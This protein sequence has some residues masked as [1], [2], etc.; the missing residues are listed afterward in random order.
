MTERPK[1]LV[2]LSRIF[3]TAALA[4]LFSLPRLTRHPWMRNLIAV[5]FGSMLSSRYHQVISFYGD[6]YGEALRIAL[7]RAAAELDP[8]PRRILDCGTGTG[9][10]AREARR[11]FPT[12]KV[13]G[14][15]VVPGMLIRARDGLSA[16]GPTLPAV[17]A[18]SLFIPFGDQSVDLVLSQNSVP[19]LDEFARVCR[20]GGLVIFVD[21][22]ATWMPP[23]ARRAAKRTGRFGH[24]VSESAGLGFYLLARR[25]ESTD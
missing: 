13:M 10:A 4:P 9:F 23:I 12:A 25:A 20:P 22:A 11:R 21:T 14:L 7:D 17:L 2:F 3:F 24:I 18:D 15:D 19:F 16:D 8:P 6:R 1:P 5:S